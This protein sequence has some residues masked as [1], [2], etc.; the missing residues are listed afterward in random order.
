VVTVSLLAG[1][2]HGRPGWTDYGMF[3]ALFFPAWWAWVN[4]MVAVNLFS[5][6]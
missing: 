6:R 5:A 1:G 3:L 2:L 4:L